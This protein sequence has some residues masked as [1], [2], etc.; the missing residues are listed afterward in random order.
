MLSY[1]V[2]YM[3]TKFSIVMIDTI[4]FMCYVL[5]LI[6]YLL[7]YIPLCLIPVSDFIFIACIIH[8]LV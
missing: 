8:S 6:G 7:V 4:F 3:L 2:L 1:A 5:S